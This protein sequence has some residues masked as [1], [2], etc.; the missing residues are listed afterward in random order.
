MV[1][2]YL[3][4]L[5]TEVTFQLLQ[6]YHSVT[7]LFSRH[8]FAWFFQTNKESAWLFFTIF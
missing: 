4:M 1:K 7:P 5:F 8:A 2:L 3:H 6:F